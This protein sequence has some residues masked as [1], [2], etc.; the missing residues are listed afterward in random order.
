MFSLLSTTRWLHT[1]FQFMRS[2]AVEIVALHRFI[3]IALYLQDFV[4]TRIHSGVNRIAMDLTNCLYLR[5]VHLNLIRLL[6]QCLDQLH[7]LAFVVTG[8]CGCEDQQ[9]A[10]FH[11]L[12]PCGGRSPARPLFQSTTTGLWKTFSLALNFL[13][14]SL[15]PV[16]S[17]TTLPAFEGPR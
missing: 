7:D 6:W 10:S 8:H 17:L 1:Q 16:A 12:L 14:A 13:N 15:L 3:G 11:I 2:R 4:W 9:K 5:A